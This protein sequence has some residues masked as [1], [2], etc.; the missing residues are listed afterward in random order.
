MRLFKNILIL[1]L[2]IFI[3]SCGNKGANKLPKGII[4]KSSYPYPPD[5]TF[6]YPGEEEIND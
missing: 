3:I 6:D 4:D 5:P 1:F 2:V